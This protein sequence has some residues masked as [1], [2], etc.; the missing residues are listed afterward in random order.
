[1]SRDPKNIHITGDGGALSRSFYL[2]LPSP[3][4]GWLL[5]AHSCPLFWRAALI[6]QEPLSTGRYIL[7]PISQPPVHSQWMTERGV[8]RL[9]PFL[10]G[11]TTL[12]WNSC[13]RAPHG[14]RLKLVSE[15]TSL[16]SFPYCLTCF[17][18]FWECFL[19]KSFAQEC[20]FQALPLGTLIWYDPWIRCFRG[21]YCTVHPSGTKEE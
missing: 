7:A 2:G 14:I 20:P 21:L 17:P 13:S 3:Q 15:T 10:L 9:A 5:M 11:K 19:N 8:Q 4:L 12:W 18:F 16:V 6:H 1:M